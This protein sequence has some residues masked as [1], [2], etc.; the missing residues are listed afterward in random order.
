MK[1]LSGFVLLP[2]SLNIPILSLQSFKPNVT[3][4]YLVH[5]TNIDY[6]VDLMAGNSYSAWIVLEQP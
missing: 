6:C 2:K 5:F 3:V 1:D 4:G